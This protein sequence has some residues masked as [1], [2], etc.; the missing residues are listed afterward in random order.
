MRDP[1]GLGTLGLCTLAL[2]SHRPTS[3]QWGSL[4]CYTQEKAYLTHT[5]KARV[6][7]AS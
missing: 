7:I 3:G 6:R 4:F 5:G 2:F 1:A